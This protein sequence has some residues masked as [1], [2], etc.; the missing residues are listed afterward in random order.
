MHVRPE[1]LHVHLV[2]CSE[3]LSPSNIEEA[4]KEFMFIAQFNGRVQVFLPILL[5]VETINDKR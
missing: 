3:Q 2:E 1:G 4:S 5:K